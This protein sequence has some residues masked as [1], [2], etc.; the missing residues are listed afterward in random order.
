MGFRAGEIDV[1]MRMVCIEESGAH[2][3]GGVLFE[4]GG[5]G[6]LGGGGGVAGGEEGGAG[7]GF[8]VIVAV[9]EAGDAGVE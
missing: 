9:A 6:L 1:R 7:E 2:R 5:N 8:V 3:G 4:V